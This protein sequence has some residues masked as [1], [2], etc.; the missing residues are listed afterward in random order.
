MTDVRWSDVGSDDVAHVRALAERRL[1]P[2]EW[3][4]YLAQ[5]ISV[6]EREETESLLAWF[7]RRY[8]T[9]ADRLR[10]ARRA[11]RRWQLAAVKP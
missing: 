10:Y 8:P 9:P 1:T 3:T 2:E 6:E 7:A 5:P 4:S 11:Y